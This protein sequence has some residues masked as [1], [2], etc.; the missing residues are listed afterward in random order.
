MF[1]LFLSHLGKSHGHA[2]MC[3]I[4]MFTGTAANERRMGDYT[5]YKLYA[6]AMT[7]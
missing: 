7:F 1:S 2:P 3:E 6:S 4:R 5:W